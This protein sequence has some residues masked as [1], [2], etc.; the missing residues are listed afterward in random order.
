ML[1]NKHLY[2]CVAIGI[3]IIHLHTF[4]DC[5]IITLSYTSHYTALLTPPDKS[6][7]EC[8][9]QLRQAGLSLLSR[10]F[11][12]SPQEQTVPKQKDAFEGFGRA[13]KEIRGKRK[14]TY[15][16]LPTGAARVNTKIDCWLTYEEYM[17]LTE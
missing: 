8:L 13:Y 2:N 1:H 6:R 16:R 4:V 12:D 17:K 11:A 9:S 7:E 10:H 14:A 5:L 3:I 15:M